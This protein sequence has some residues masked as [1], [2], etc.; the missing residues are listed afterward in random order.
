MA[1]SIYLKTVSGL[2]FEDLNVSPATGKGVFSSAA[3]NGA[4]GITLRNLTISAPLAGI[5]SDNPADEGWLIEAVTIDHTGDS[6]I[7]FKGSNFVIADSSILDTGTDASI[8]YP[9]HAIYAAGP[10]RRS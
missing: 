6:G 4:Q 3:G 5:N 10:T 1:S 9:R 2:T 7:Y 8:R